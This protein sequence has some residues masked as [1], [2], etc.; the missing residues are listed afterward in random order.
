MEEEDGE[1]SSR[2][3]LW[4]RL[5]VSLWLRERMAIAQFEFISG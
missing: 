3:G 2:K 1:G 4:H 5:H